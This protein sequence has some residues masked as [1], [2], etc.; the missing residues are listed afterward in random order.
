MDK[1]D[2]DCRNA[3]YAIRTGRMSLDEFICWICDYSAEALVEG[4]SSIEGDAPGGPPPLPSSGELGRICAFDAV[5]K[6]EPRD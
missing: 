2:E 1:L 5:C 6:F 3:F 4:Q